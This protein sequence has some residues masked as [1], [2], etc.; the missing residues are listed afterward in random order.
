MRRL[1]RFG[2]GLLLL[3]HMRTK[4][5]SMSSARPFFDVQASGSQVY[6][7][8]NISEVS[9]NGAT[10]VL[11]SCCTVCMGASI[12]GEPKVCLRE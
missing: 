12:V 9:E 8:F 4:T 5:Y 11:E 3:L 7:H 2:Q 10:R 1:Q 6:E